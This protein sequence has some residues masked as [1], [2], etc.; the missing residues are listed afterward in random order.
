MQ[1]IYTET[2]GI[3]K[4]SRKNLAIVL[5][6]ANVA[7]SAKEVADLLNMTSV[8]AA[9]QLKNWKQNGWIQRITRGWYTPIPLESQVTEIAIEDIWLVASKIFAPAYIG[10][11]S[12]IEHW[13][14]TEQIFQSLFVFTSKTVRNISPALVGLTVSLHQVPQDRFFGLESVWVGTEKVLVSNPSKTLIDVLNQPKY[15]GGIRLVDDLL[16]NYLSSE[17]FKPEFLI[18]YANNMNN[19]TIFKRL[20]FLLERIDKSQEILLATC[21]KNLSQGYSFLD[22]ALGGDRVS[23]RWKLKLPSS[24]KD[25]D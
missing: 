17:Y 20:G 15:A 3:G 5:E 6:K 25:N 7:F 24:W 11:Y 14:L 23:T 10:G 8:Q 16:K 22:P 12:A 4:T 21:K 2:A 9:T 18:E 13:S 19:K 1:K